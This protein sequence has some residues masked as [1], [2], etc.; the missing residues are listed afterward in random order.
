MTQ[1][2]QQQSWTDRSGYRAQDGAGASDDIQA[3]LRRNG[4]HHAQSSLG[5]LGIVGHWV[6]LAGTLAPIVIGELV[7][8]PAK[9]WK[10][11]R[12]ASVG[13]SVAYEAVHTMNELARRREQAA[14]LAACKEEEQGRGV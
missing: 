13:T 8:D 9:R 3:T 2:Y 4:F 11:I 14:K 1:Q 7:D 12:L 6:G 5:S 10:I